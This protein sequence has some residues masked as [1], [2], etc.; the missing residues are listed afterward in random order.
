MRGL[1]KRLSFAGRGGAEG[2]QVRDLEEKLETLRLK[3]AEDKGKT[4]RAGETQDPAEQQVQEWKSKMQGDRQ[5]CSGEP[6]G[7]SEG[8]TWG[9]EGVWGG[10]G[11]RG[12]VLEAGTGAWTV[13][14]KGTWASL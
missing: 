2:A 6:Q 5:T 1:G 7:G 13:L 12:G 14:T 3:R 11:A 4:E 10:T 9:E 8:G